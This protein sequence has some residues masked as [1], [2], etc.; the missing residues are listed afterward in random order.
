[1]K[2]QCPDNECLNKNSSR[3]SGRIVR[4]GS[5]FRRSDGQRIPRFLCRN[6]SRTFSTATFVAAYRQKKRKLNHPLKILLSSGVSQRRAAI[7]L[8]VNKK[9]IVRKFHFLAEQARLEHAR[10]MKQFESKPLSYIQF[11]DLETIEHTKCK[12]LSVALAVEPTTRKILDFQVSQMPAKGPLSKI[13]VQKYGARPDLRPF[14]WNTMFANLKPVTHERARWVS[15]ENPHYPKFLR[16]HHPLSL[17]DPKPGARGCIAGQ[18]ELKKLVFDPMFSL[19]HTCAMLRANINRLFRRTWCSTKKRQG[20]IDHL[21]IY[22][23]YHNEVLTGA[24]TG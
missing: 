14:G 1:M 24:C 19:N 9:T 5:F 12:P 2:R 13:S 4:K 16:R 15:D 22:V 7:I 10:W 23:R 18:G 20:L 6:C 21:S 8:R 3:D 11:D 17:H